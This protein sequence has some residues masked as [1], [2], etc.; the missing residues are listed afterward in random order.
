[1]K[2]KYTEHG[3]K[4]MSEQLSLLDLFDSIQTE[5]FNEIKKIIDSF[6]DPEPNQ[7]VV[8]YFVPQNTGWSGGCSWFDS[9]DSRKFTDVESANQYNEML[10]KEFKDEEMRFRV[11]KRVIT[12]TVIA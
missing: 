5:K 9:S 6:S 10:R 4:Q 7:R 8:E 2:T 3:E 11:I 12:E 1:M